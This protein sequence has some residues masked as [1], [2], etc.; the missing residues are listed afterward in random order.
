MGK[1]WILHNKQL[2]AIPC[3]CGTN[4]EKTDKTILCEDYYLA[5]LNNKYWLGSVANLI[6]KA[7]VFCGIGAFNNYIIHECCISK[8]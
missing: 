7:S 2:L 8:N 6:G 4:R 5:V 3:A 1:A